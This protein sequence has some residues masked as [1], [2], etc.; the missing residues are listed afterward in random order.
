MN[1]ANVRDQ[2]DPVELGRRIRE[3]RKSAGL[4]QSEL[5]GEDMSVA[6][7][8]RI[9]AGTRRPEPAMLAAL[10]G[11]LH[12]TPDQLMTGRDPSFAAEAE[13]QLRYA[14][15]A[16]ESGEAAEALEVSARF[17]NEAE[18]NRWP[19]L[20]LEARHL[21]AR[22]LEVTGDLEQ[23]AA[24]LEQLRELPDLGA[25]WTNAM[26]VLARVYRDAGDLNRSIDV[27]EQALGRLRA[28]GLDGQGQAVQLALTVAASYFERG[29]ELYAVS[30][31]KRAIQAGDETGTAESRASAYWNASIMEARRGDYASAIAHANRALALLSEGLDERNLARLRAQLGVL[32]LRSPEP[33]VRQ[34][35]RHLKRA[36]RDLARGSGTAVDLARCDVHLA[37]A[38]F[39][40][41][42]LEGAEVL[43]TSALEGLEPTVPMLIAEAQTLLGRIAAARG[44]TRTEVGQR[45][46]AAV[47]ALSACAADRSAARAWYELGA[48][49]DELGDEQSARDAYRSAAAASGLTIPL[50]P[51]PLRASRVGRD[52]RPTRSARG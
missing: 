7:V 45:Y 11:R 24:E 6:Y 17:L 28:A 46:R 13:L 18:S 23:A 26:I 44:D 52:R 29:D 19:R 36:R 8:S 40:D 1:T 4:T 2:V 37:L 33:D 10:A 41:D 15:L 34:A 21:H 22:A 25:D 51:T 32:L 3:L 38:R 16:L 39:Q 50:A 31:C 49:F 20:V 9:E 43:V 47:A 30:T 5:A 14:A 12:T 48:L 27:G 42:D 35:E